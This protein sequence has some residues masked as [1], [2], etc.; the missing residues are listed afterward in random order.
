M[1]LLGGL[2]ARKHKSSA[3]SIHS[4]ANGIAP[5]DVDS[6]LSSPTNS[7]IT[8]DRSL[9]SS[10]NGKNILNSDS[11]HLTPN[12]Y[13]TPTSAASS[14]LRLPFS[15]KKSRVPIKD[16]SVV[17][18][19]THTNSLPP[20]RVNHLNS[21]GAYDS[22]TG[23]MRP[24][25]PPPAVFGAY[26]DPNGA[27]STQSLPNEP[28]PSISPRQHKEKR[29]SLFSWTKEPPQSK[30]LPDPKNE[31]NLNSP[32][33]LEPDSS[34]NLKSFRHLRPSS[35]D[36]S[37]CSLVVP[38]SRPRNASVNSESSQ[39]ISVAAFRE[40]QA[41]RS[42]AGSPAPSYR[43]PSPSS[44]FPLDGQRG[45]LSSRPSSQ[46]INQRRSTNLAVGYTSDSD[47][48]T[49]SE[50][51]DSD[52]GLNRR[53]DATRTPGKR[54]RAGKRQAKSEIGHGSS[55]HSPK[56]Q[57]GFS[58]TRSH[59]GHGDPDQNVKQTYV[60]IPP[61]PPTG[62]GSRP[63]LALG[64]NGTRRRA[65]NSTSALS[66]SAAAK[67]ASVLAT[68]NAAFDRDSSAATKQTNY[69]A[70]ESLT[71]ANTPLIAKAVKQIDDSESESE[72][73]N[74]P[75]ACL[76]PPRRPGSSMSSASNASLKTNGTRGL[77]GRAMSKPLIDINELTTKK[78]TIGPQKSNDDA[79]TGSGLIASKMHGPQQGLVESPTS[80]EF[81][82]PLTSKSP[83]GST[84]FA[85][86]LSPSKEMKAHLSMD[87]KSSSSSS[88]LSASKVEKSPSPERR[89]DVL[90]ERLAK[91]AKA[92][93]IADEANARIKEK[94]PSPPPP[95]R[96]KSMQPELSLG[97]S[98]GTMQPIV[99]SE[100][101]PPD[102][103]LIQ[104]VDQ[105]ILNLISRIGG[106][107]ENE[108]P[109]ANSKPEEGEKSSDSE[110]DA[111]GEPD[112]NK[113]R[114]KNVFTNVK[115]LPK[116]PFTSSP[117][118]E[119]KDRIAPI[120]IKQRAPAPSF[121]VMSRP[122][123]LRLQEDDNRS[124][125][126]TST[127]AKLGLSS[128]RSSTT[129]DSITGTS[130]D[131]KRGLSNAKSSTN[132]DSTSPTPQPIPSPTNMRRQR[133]STMI[134]LS[135]PSSTFGATTSSFAK[136][137]A[138]EGTVVPPSNASVTSPSDSRNVSKTPNLE[139]AAVPKTP[140]SNGSE[141]VSSSNAP[142]SSAS[143]SQASRHRAKTVGGGMPNQTFSRPANSSPVPTMPAKPFAMRRDSPVSS[144]GDSSSGRAPLTP[145]DGSDIYPSRKPGDKGKDR[146]EE[147]GSGVSGLSVPSSKGTATAHAPRHV[148]RRSVSFEDEIKDQIAVSSAGRKLK[149]VESDDSEVRRRERRRS[150]AKAAIELGN[151]INGPG[152][153]VS[154]DEDDLPANQV[155]NAARMSTMN[156]MMGMNNPMQMQFNGSPAAWG[157]NMS[158]WPQQAGP[159]M[160][161]PAPYMIPPPPEPH[162]YAAHHQAMMYAKQ[163]YQMAVA[164]Q[165][166]AAAADEWERS[167]AMGGSVYGGGSNASVMMSS[168]RYGMM[169]MGG[170]NN[171]WSTGSMIF[172]SSPQSAY[173]G[174]GGMN[175]SRSEYGGGGGGG[176]GR[177]S[178]ARSTYG[179]AFGPS[180]RL[181]P[182]MAA[183]GG[184][185]HSGMVRDSGYHPPVPP[186][187]QNHGGRSSPAKVRNRTASGPALATREGQ[188]K[189]PPSSWKTGL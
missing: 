3:R 55:G 91:L 182:G 157:G 184:N 185:R 148:K 67:R 7:Y 113:H 177:W 165:A 57:S 127:G 12:H 90:T 131:T 89:R 115:D 104:D 154:D 105:N 124:S 97:R 23:D 133:S 79:F 98:L 40:A 187:P 132:L 31:I 26:T 2:F 63:Q 82:S 43:S 178:S 150:E 54:P 21:S 188:R 135:T 121:S 93:A 86:P 106:P 60:G 175:S 1:P 167:S 34:F 36:A 109:D 136:L 147:W 35:P 84:H 6:A 158:P 76:V 29:P 137:A 162:Y 58:A 145:R 66:P 95:Q 61:I 42:T 129:L 64:V 18:S 15:R 171:G 116:V 189:P 10:P 50:E 14:K 13:L 134:P 65:S 112:D 49:S 85:R 183:G 108:M 44:P 72:D 22:D 38:P 172:P 74:A 168:P 45:R 114:Q 88:Q 130:T 126:A 62:Q 125:S 181:R 149:E 11:G 32:L 169:G 186:I 128:A 110:S 51:E 160:L 27:L 140:E 8:A 179:E 24:L 77:P 52:D 68:A 122:P 161:S 47:D 163:A 48:S 80:A 75:L 153:V 39:R 25:R 144:A 166:M 59:T 159:Q 101:S 117:E 170:I 156:P 28:I 5:S 46:A 92:N 9:P 174:R 56:W 78:P 119:D 99:K 120:P 71:A 102:E 107:E 81:P 94:S 103:G 4:T 118:P 73:D 87:N 164:Q 151:V 20:P 138:R 96:K 123:I 142:S 155:M 19:H 69:P 143:S 33:Q 139:K 30:P 53:N 141:A 152:P 176:G 41:R 70:G 83:P 146:G 17:P 100:P 180:D 16:P 173:G 111:Y 37:N